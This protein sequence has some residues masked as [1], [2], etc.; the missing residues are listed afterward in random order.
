MKLMRLLLLL[1]IA[2]PAWAQ[3]KV[4][5]ATGYGSYAMGD[6]KALQKELLKDFPAGAR[7][8][9]EFPAFLYYEL[10]ATYLLNETFTVGGLVNYGSTGGRINYTDYSG[11]VSGNQLIQFVSAGAWLGL[12]LTGYEKNFRVHLDVRPQ[13]SYSFLNLEF[14]SRLGNYD[15]EES[16]KFNSLNLAI[17]PGIRAEY[18]RTRIGVNIF[19][20]YNINAIKGDLIWS[21]NENAYLQNEDGDKIYLDL[22]GFRVQVGVFYRF[23]AN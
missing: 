1:M 23:G 2:T 21:E 6:M 13:F 10:N 16:I 8:T 22:S 11:E 19:A 14:Y 5:L 3:L 4:G 17:E 18:Y 12:Q 9:E 15:D 20:G 7:I